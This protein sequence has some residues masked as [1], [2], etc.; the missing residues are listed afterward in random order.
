MLNSDHRMLIL[1]LATLVNHLEKSGAESM[2]VVNFFPC[3]SL[4]WNAFCCRKMEMI[5]D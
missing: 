3:F 5:V 1:A 2:S 4:L